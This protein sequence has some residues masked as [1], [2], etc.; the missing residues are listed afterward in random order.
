LAFLDP[1]SESGSTDLFKSESTDLFESGYYI[2]IV[3]GPGACGG[4]DRVCGGVPQ[5]GAMPRHRP[6]AYTPPE[7]HCRQHQ[8]G[9]QSLHF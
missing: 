5:P 6:S 9:I 7:G 1:Y 2:C 8:K 3:G 4:S